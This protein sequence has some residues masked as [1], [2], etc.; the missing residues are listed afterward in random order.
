MTAEDGFEDLLRVPNTYPGGN[1]LYNTSVGELQREIRER[2]VRELHNTNIT[3]TDNNF[4]REMI[5]MTVRDPQDVLTTNPASE[6]VQPTPPVAGVNIRPHTTFRDFVVREPIAVTELGPI[7]ATEGEVEETE[8]E[9]D[10]EAERIRDEVVFNRTA[11][12]VQGEI[13]A[14]SMDASTSRFFSERELCKANKV[15]MTGI[16]KTDSILYAS[17]CYSFLENYALM[18]LT[19]N[20]DPDLSKALDIF[21]SI[22]DII[23]DDCEVQFEEE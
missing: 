14:D 21:H 1:R 18:C 2:L 19:K 13:R 17:R 12:F 22:T 8:P 20:Q 3:L 16:E 9:E 6:V 7:E 15:P 10:A 23:K 11:G 5:R 4:F